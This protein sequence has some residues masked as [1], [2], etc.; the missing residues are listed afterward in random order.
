MQLVS[1]TAAS[2]VAVAV[3]GVDLVP[4][5]VTGILPSLM[6][7]LVNTGIGCYL[8]FSSITRL[9]AQTVAACDYVEPLSAVLLSAMVLGESM[10]PSQLFGAALVIV[11]A[12]SCELVRRGHRT[13]DATEKTSR[14]VRGRTGGLVTSP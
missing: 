10:A 6:L 14:G 13:T 12:V 1:A 8:Y 7:G 4:I 3:Q 5:P 9:S 2:L 11:G